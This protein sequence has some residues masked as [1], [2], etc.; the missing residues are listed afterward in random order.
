MG[1]TQYNYRWAALP[2][3][4][5]SIDIT[6]LEVNFLI[7]RPGGSGLPLPSTLL[8]VGVAEDVTWFS[9]NLP[10]ASMELTAPSLSYTYSGFE[11]VDTIDL[12]DEPFSSLHSVT[13]S[14][15]NYT[16][17]GRYIVFYAPS[18]ESAL[19]TSTILPPVCAPT[20]TPPPIWTTIK[21]SSS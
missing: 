4:D 5:D 15:E 8:I 21:F 7:Q 14:F 6:S 2:R 20:E 3:L 11:P 1:A 18:P 9:G 13:V 16:G 12:N 17:D 19:N 10:A